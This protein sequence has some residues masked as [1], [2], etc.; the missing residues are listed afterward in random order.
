MSRDLRSGSFE[1]ALNLHE[2]TDFRFEKDPERGNAMRM[3]GVG[4]ISGQAFLLSS[5][6]GLL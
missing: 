2:C 4:R 6:Q 5:S 3:H 1:P